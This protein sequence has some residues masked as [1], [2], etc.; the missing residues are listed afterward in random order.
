MDA[1][2]L[3]ALFEP[4]GP[5]T[6]KRM[7]GGAGVYAEGLCF[8]IELRGEVFLKTD[9]LS[10]AQFSAVGSEPFV[11]VAKG[12]S[13]PTSYWSLPA[14]AHEDGDELRRWATT[15]F[16]AARRAAAARA[17]PRKAKPKKARA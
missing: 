13:R 1:E 17:K 15:G 8:A 10:Q 5:I 16:E 14:A 9:A 7:F 3:K 11:Y 4:F 12:Q 2:G 6:V